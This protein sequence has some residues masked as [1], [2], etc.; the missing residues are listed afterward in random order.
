MKRQLLL[1]SILLFS[2]SATAYDAYID[3]I[4]Y[5]LN[6]D[7]K[8]AEVTYGSGVSSY[9]DTVI[10]PQTVNYEE[11]PYKITSIGENA[12]ERCYLNYV[13]IGWINQHIFH[14]LNLYFDYYHC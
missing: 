1:L 3:G 12:F 8:T 11:V 5:N 9:S 4:Y 13:K 14:Y 6:K 7:A 2:L 10:I